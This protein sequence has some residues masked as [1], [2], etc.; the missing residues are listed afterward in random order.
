MQHPLHCLLKI[1][2]RIGVRI[3]VTVMVTVTVT[4]TGTGTVRVLKTRDMVRRVV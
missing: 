1:G 2:V 3:R 4:V